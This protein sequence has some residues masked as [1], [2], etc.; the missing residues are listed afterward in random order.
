M[1]GLVNERDLPRFRDPHCRIKREGVRLKFHVG[2]ETDSA[3]K[4]KIATTAAL[5]RDVARAGR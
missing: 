2:P 5:M 3:R 4:A 1:D